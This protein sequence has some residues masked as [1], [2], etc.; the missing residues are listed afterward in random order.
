MRPLSKIA[1]CISI[2]D[3]AWCLCSIAIIALFFFSVLGA[4]GANPFRTLLAMLR[5]AFGNSTGIIETLTR[6]TPILLCALAVAI[7]ARAGIFNIGGEGQLYWGAIGA[8]F[9]ALRFSDLPM[10]LAILAMFSAAALA[11][12]LW[13]CIPALLKAVW[14]VNEILVA[15]MLNY[16]AFFVVEHLVHGPWRDPSAVGW[17][18]SARF[19]DSMVLPT[20][21]TTN[22]HLGLVFA[23]CIAILLS[24]VMRYT[25]V[26]FSMKVIEANSRVAKHVGIRI[27]RYVLISM[28]LGG[29]LAALAGVGEVSVIQGRLRPGISPGY[30]YAGFLVAWLSGHRFGLIIPASILIGGLYSGAD[31]LQL[32]AGLPAATAD[33]LMGMVFVGFLVGNHFRDRFT[34][35]NNGEEAS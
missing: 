4:L 35:L 33:I 23:V 26:G 9:V 17:P 13:A 28:A 7:P 31:E 1:R 5:G 34:P 19:S 21:G 8:T 16:V 22:L 6:A 20:Y 2:R 30:G 25:A 27:V 29:A 24:L 14:N 15:L 32:T 11:G 12:G 3:L 10:P 18:Y